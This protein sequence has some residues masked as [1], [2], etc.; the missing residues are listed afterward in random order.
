MN[1][2]ILYSYP[3]SLAFHIVAVI[4]AGLLIQLHLLLKIPATTRRALN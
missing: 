1:H 2:W 3:A 4:A